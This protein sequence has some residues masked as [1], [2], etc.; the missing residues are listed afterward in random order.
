[1]LALAAA[2]CATATAP[3]D[4]VVEEEEDDNN[5]GRDVGGNGGVDDD[6][7]EETDSDTAVD[8]APDGSTAP[9][10]VDAGTEDAGTGDA[11]T[12]DSGT[13]DADAQVPDADSGGEVDADA[14]TDVDP[15]VDDADASTDAGLDSE[16]D[17]SGDT[18][19]SVTPELCGNGIDD[20]GDR[21]V[22][23]ADTECASD[24]L[25]TPSSA[26]GT[27]ADPILAAVRTQRARPTVDEQESTCL[28]ISQN[29]SVFVFTPP[30]TGFWCFDTRGGAAADTILSV[31][32]TCTSV[33]TE[34][35]CR[36]EVVVENDTRFEQRSASLTAGTP[37]YVIV[38]T[39]SGAGGSSPTPEI[40]LTIQA[41][42]CGGGAGT[43]DDLGEIDCTD[44]ADDVAPDAEIG[45]SV[46][47]TC[48]NDCNPDIYFVLGT[49]TYRTLSWI[50]P[51]ARH[52]GAVTL[53]GG[54]V[55]VNFVEPLASYTGST[56]NGVTTD[57]SPLEGERAFTVQAAP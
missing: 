9:D 32:T 43:V 52:A 57:G 4:E 39:Y 11:G 37:V 49:D 14:L 22:D 13:G 5:G 23:C 16:L 38:D 12:G 36:D 46:R 44:N 55:L 54:P 2:G 51:A 8:D 19:D 34:L 53:A 41:G 45:T 21:A 18:S 7:V 56:R 31:R 33:S 50:C 24:A 40:Q 48:P 15:D 20:D 10:A 35:F 27:C 25:C 29:E 42:A 26:A 3:N 1:M 30:T 28:S 17:G 6:T 47:V